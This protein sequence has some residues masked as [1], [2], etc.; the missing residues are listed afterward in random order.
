[1]PVCPVELREAILAREREGKSLVPER[2][3][4]AIAVSKAVVRQ[5]RHGTNASLDL[6]NAAGSMFF[7]VDPVTGKSVRQLLEDVN[8]PGGVQIVAPPLRE[9]IL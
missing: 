5:K 8:D 1:M 2:I 4:R 7:F 6:L 9:Q 3:A